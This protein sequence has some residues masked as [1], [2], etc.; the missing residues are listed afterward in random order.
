M[1]WSKEDAQ[2]VGIIAALIAV[3]KC[4]EIQKKINSGSIDTLDAIAIWSTEYHEFTKFFDWE[5]VMEAEEF[6]FITKAGQF[7]N[8]RGGCWDDF[9]ISFVQAKLNDKL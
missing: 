6:T 2:D 8:L 1:T 5:K 4:D 3:N 9:I 7:C